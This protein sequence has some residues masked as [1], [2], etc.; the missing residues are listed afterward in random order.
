MRRWLAHRNGAAGLP[1]AGAH[2]DRLLRAGGVQQPRD[3]GLR[4]GQHQHTAPAADDP[5]DP[6]QDEGNPPVHGREPGEVHDYAPAHL[7]RLAFEEQADPRA[8]TD[9]GPACQRHH[10]ARTAAVVLQRRDQRPGLNPLTHHH[11]YREAILV[12]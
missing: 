9:D 12:S 3:G 10:R 7:F 2:Y 6:D 4:S 11:L 8:V 1:D 5:A